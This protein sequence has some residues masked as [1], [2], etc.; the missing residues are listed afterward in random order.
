MKPT[1]ANFYTNVDK[2]L[3]DKTLQKALRKT[4]VGFPM[5]RAKA[6]DALP[7]FD[8]LRDDAV[9]LKNDVLDNLDYYLERFETKAIEQGGQVHW[10]SD[11]QEANETVL[12]ICQA[13]NAKTVTKGKSMIGE[14]MG[15]NEYLEEHGIEPIET[16]L[17]EYIIQL[18]NEPPSHIVGPAIHVPKEEVAE[19]FKEAH[20][21]LDAERSLEEPQELLEEARAIL[22]EKFINA[23]V[24]ITGANFL[25]A[26]TGSS[27]IV[28][29][30]GN[31]D[32]TQILPR[33]HIVLASI[34]KVVPTLEDAS[35]ILRVLARSIT[36]QDLSVYTTFSTGPRRDDDIDGPEEFHVIL[37]DN[38]RSEMLGNEF[39]DML[40][41]IRCGSCLGHCPIYTT[42]GGHA[43]G[44]VY[45]GPMGK[46]L[47]PN[48]I[49]HEQSKH[50][51]NACTMCGKCEEVC[52]L[53]IP[54]PTMNRVWRG[55]EHEAKYSSR[56]SRIALGF[57]AFMAKR[58]KLYHLL[59]GFKYSILGKIGRKKGRFTS[60]PFASAWT[61][62]RDLPSPQG[63]TFQQQWSDRGG[64]R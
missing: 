55:K 54:I 49:G 21:E 22:R 24:G 62:G 58:P 52:P 60:V 41:C 1:S 10:C 46:V 45:S 37:L 18:R 3:V 33:V 53:R 63:R 16:D 50:L 4:A 57:W 51:P 9:T 35:T 42:I 32:L 7:E 23:D 27:A 61:E 12:K 38:G 14:E 20:T 15:V 29:N 39:R 59:A 8:T 28:T 48:L 47:I 56:A 34:E 13:A 6:I 43:Y 36:G 11:T 31:G 44:W 40:R 5:L 64:K 17:G 2:A 19:A 26:E 30:E 25:V